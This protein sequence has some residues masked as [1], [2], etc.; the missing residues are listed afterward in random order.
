MLDTY[1]IPYVYTVESSNGF[2]YDPEVKM[3]YE[4]NLEKFI[5]LGHYLG[6]ALCDHVSLLTDYE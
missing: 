6:V 1:K 4:F 5:E 2:Y 3:T